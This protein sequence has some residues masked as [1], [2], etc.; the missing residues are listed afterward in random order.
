MSYQLK[1]I[2][3]DEQ[4]DV[5]VVGAGAAG[6]QA[7]LFAAMAG[8]LDRAVGE[9]SPLAMRDAFIRNGAKALAHIERNSEL[10]FR[11]REIHPDYISELEGSTLGG[12]AFE[13]LPFDGRK[14]G[15]S[16]A[17]VRPPDSG[18]YRF[19]RH[20]GRPRRAIVAS[21]QDVQRD[22]LLADFEKRG[23]VGYVEAIAKPDDLEVGHGDPGF[24]MP[25]AERVSA[26]G[27]GLVRA[28]PPAMADTAERG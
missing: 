3:Q 11:M 8:Y 22:Q 28:E 9:R 2:A 15:S 12:R 5:V 23:V 16:F 7:A 24:Q 18:I 13:P 27:M 20:D 4:Y 1:D 17:L 10:K 6:M 19:G 14:L 25:C 26:Q 21:N